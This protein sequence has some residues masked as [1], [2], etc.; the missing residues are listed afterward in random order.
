MGVSVAVVQAHNPRKVMFVHSDNRHKF[1][2]HGKHSD[3][4]IVLI[5]VVQPTGIE[6]YE[7]IKGSH[8][9]DLEQF[10]SAT[11]EMVPVSLKPGNIM[12]LRSAL[13]FRSTLKT[14]EV[15]AMFMYKLS[16]DEG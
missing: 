12:I 8:E 7:Y 13:I 15:C 2:T 9:K 10:T 6:D 16:A 1:W 14:G 5:P 4:L 11:A 3:I